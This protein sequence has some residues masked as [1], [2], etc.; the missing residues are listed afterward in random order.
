MQ[1]ERAGKKLQREGKR[2]PSVILELV[3]HVQKTSPLGFGEEP[4]VLAAKGWHP[5]HD[6]HPYP[7]TLPLHHYFDCL[8]S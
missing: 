2:F 1:A 7:N 6:S 4:R 5:L 3:P 8:S